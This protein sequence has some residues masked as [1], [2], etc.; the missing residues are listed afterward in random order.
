M[1][2]DGALDAGAFD[3]LLITTFDVKFAVEQSI[4][5]STCA[6]TVRVP[7]T[8]ERG[9][10]DSLEHVSRGWLVASHRVRSSIRHSDDDT[11]IC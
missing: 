6:L 8:S 10:V 4:V 11:I 2:V 5:F 7:L 3:R 9:L 1:L